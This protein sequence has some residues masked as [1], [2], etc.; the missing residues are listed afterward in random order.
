MHLR[1]LRRRVSAN[2]ALLTTRVRHLCSSMYQPN[3]LPHIAKGLGQ[4]CTTQCT[5]IQDTFFH[6]MTGLT[7]Q[8][9][10]LKLGLFASRIMDMDGTPLSMAPCCCAVNQVDV[11]FHWI[12]AASAGPTTLLGCVGLSGCFLCGRGSVVMD[13]ICC[14]LAVLAGHE[15]CFASLMP[16]LPKTMLRSP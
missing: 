11:L 15:F 2:T 12:S 16:M 9:G 4:I 1:L 6:I 14:M 13:A 7:R 8:P 5:T 10:H 3:R